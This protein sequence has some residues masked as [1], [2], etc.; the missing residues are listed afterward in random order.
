MLPWARQSGLLGGVILLA[1]SCALVRPDR[2][3]AAPVDLPGEFSSDGGRAVSTNRWWTSFDSPALDALVEQALASNFDIRK[4]WARLDQARE[5]AI[6]AGADRWP[7]LNLDASA[8]RAKTISTVTGAPV[9]ATADTFALGVAASYEVDL[10]GRVSAGAKA[11]RYDWQASRG[12]LETA[13]L[14]VAAELAETWFAA[15]EQQAQLRL[16]N[17]QL[18]VSRSYRELTELRFQ[19]GQASAL[20]V[21]Q[22]R[23]QEA[24]V[25]AQ[26]PPVEA[27]LAVLKNALAVLTGKAPGRLDAEI[28]DRLPD[29][30]ARPGA[31]LPADLLQNRPDVRAAAARLRAADERVH[32]AVANRLPTLRL[33]G[34]AGYQ[35]AE[36]EDLFDDWIWNLAAGLTGPILD[37]G[38]RASEARRTRAAAE[39]ALNAYG[40]TLL[41]ALREVEDA[42]VQEDRQ[43]ELLDRQR[44]QLDLARQTLTEARARYRAGLSDYLPVLTALQTTQILERGAIAAHR[45]WLSY[46]LQL[47]RAL[48][49][50]WTREL[51]NPKSEYR[52]SK[53]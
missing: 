46:R 47:H 36:L 28:A 23:Q 35:N 29:A 34:G 27:R 48:G 44:E 24:S 42:L 19:Q 37:G 3:R 5:L 21:Y 8:R 39:E 17:D 43:R 31:G 51:Q 13:A 52:N 16:L 32:A 10:W 40:Q 26:I 18:E 25:R 15:I 30:P 11:A 7:G 49:G 6:Q 22:Q 1:S 2:E 45:Q 20:D 38:R 41:K 53:Q 9:A 33:T 12:D 4:A 50:D 14:S